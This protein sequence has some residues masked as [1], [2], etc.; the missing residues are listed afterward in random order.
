[1]KMKITERKYPLC[2]ALATALV[3]A[4]VA[5]AASPAAS[6]ASAGTGKRPNIVIILGDDLGFSDMG[7]FGG[8]I[9]T[10]NLDSL[11][12]AGVRCT[13]FYTHASCSPT[14]SMLLT[15]VDTHLN[16]LG[17]MDEWTAFASRSPTAGTRSSRARST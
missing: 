4:T 7:C 5:T 8:E 13:Q 11:A 15:G 2:A 14:R 9:K 17:N 1:M 10:P 16:G 6:P 12:Q 3:A